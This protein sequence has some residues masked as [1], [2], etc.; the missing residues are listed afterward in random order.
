[1]AEALHLKVW[2]LLAIRNSFLKG[3][4]QP[5]MLLFLYIFN[6]RTFIYLQLDLRWVCWMGKNI[7]IYG[8]DMLL[9]KKG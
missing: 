5:V 2:L 6:L 7:G 9:P 8:W 4:V 1:M 3:S